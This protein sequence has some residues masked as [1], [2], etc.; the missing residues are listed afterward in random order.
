MKTVRYYYDL[1]KNS[2]DAGIR[3]NEVNI[4]RCNII[5]YLVCCYRL[6]WMKTKL[7]MGYSCET[8]AALMNYRKMATVKLDGNRVKIMMGLWE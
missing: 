7:D 3:F 2:I 1:L 4:Y 5:Q 8:V 6:G